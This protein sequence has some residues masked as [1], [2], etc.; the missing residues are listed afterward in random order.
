[1]LSRKPPHVDPDG[2]WPALRAAG[3]R[4]A[5]TV[6]DAPVVVTGLPD[7]KLPDAITFPLAYAGVQVTAGPRAASFGVVVCDRLFEQVLHAACGGPA[8]AAAGFGAPPWAPVVDAFS[9]SPRTFVSIYQ[10]S[11]R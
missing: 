6:D 3:E 11:I 4:V 1:M 5:A 8:E 10:S 7:F 2:G 9:A